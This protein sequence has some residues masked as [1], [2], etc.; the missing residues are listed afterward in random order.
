MAERVGERCDASQVTLV[1]VLPESFF[2]AP[3][4][5]AN[6][7]VGPSHNLSLPPPP[8]AMLLGRLSFHTGDPGQT[9]CA[10]L[11]NPP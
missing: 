7:A 5:L 2:D 10:S 8:Y 6:Q 1:V 4:T 11:Q 9:V 3:S